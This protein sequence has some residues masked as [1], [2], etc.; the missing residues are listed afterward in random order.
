LDYLK[1]DRNYSER[2]ISSYCSDIEKFFSFLDNEGMLFDH[3]DNIA[4]R[5]FLDKE[6][7]SK[8]TKRSCKR[9]ISSL[10]G[11]YS[12]LKNKKYISTNP[13]LTIKSPKIEKTYPKT[14]YED[15]INAILDANNKREDAM[16]D[17]DQAILETL[18][19]TGIRA[20]ELVNIKIQDFNLR[21]RTLRLVGK[22]NKERQVPFSEECKESI[23]KY[24]NKLR[25]ELLKK[26]LMPSPY[27]FLNAKGNQL[28]RR[29]LQYILKEIESNCT[30]ISGIH[31]HIFRHTFAT[32]LLEKGLD[33]RDIQEL[34]G[35]ESLNS[36]QVYSHISDETIRQSYIENF[37]RA[38]KK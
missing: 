7:N 36:T 31:P 2:T 3:V 14:L 16:K 34:L 9:R 20:S 5:N 30:N 38:K 1:Y 18:Y 11:F 26:A 17:R 27:L 35:H 6:L 28:T 24:L 15:Q 4:I 19:F 25:P 21:H 32:T 23:E 8:I 29:G 37:P 33:L 12:F 10:K 22:G 13:F